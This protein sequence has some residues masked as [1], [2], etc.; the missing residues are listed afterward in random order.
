MK[1]GMKKFVLFGLLLFMCS[2]SS[3][4]AGRFTAELSYDDE[5]RQVWKFFNTKNYGVIDASV[6]KDENGIISAT[7]KAK[8]V[9]A[10]LLATETIQAQTSI[11][12]SLAGIV[13]MVPR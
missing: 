8:E 10:T 4:Y 5:G 3:M 7:F 1:W 2:C 11:I 9:N 12:N 13:G 6:A